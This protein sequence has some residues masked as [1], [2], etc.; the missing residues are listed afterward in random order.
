[1]Q[2]AENFQAKLAR[3]VPLHH[4]NVRPHT[5]R[6]TQERI[7]EVQWELLEHPPY[8]PDLAPSN[9]PL[10]AQLNKK[11]TRWWQIFR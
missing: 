11:T 5:A 10:F 9:F 1:M 2:V 3:R 7:Q 6:A 4:D 8:S